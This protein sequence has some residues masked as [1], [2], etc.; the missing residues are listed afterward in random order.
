MDK[1]IIK[2]ISTEEKEYAYALALRDK[3][4]RK[5]LGLSIENDDLSKEARAYHVVAMNKED[6]VGTLYLI[7]LQEGVL[8]MKQVAVDPDFQGSGIGQQLVQKA[9]D[10]AASTGCMEIQLNARS[11]AWSFYKNCGYRFV[12]GPFKEVGITHKKMKKRLDIG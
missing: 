11:N 10:A 3:V 9:E 8:Q 6:V 5:P 2:V 7:S 12:S 1:A 4:L